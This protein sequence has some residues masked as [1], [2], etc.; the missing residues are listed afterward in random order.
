MSA[1]NLV[2]PTG[3]PVVGLPVVAAFCLNVWQ[4][5]I[6]MGLRKTSGVKY[7]TL[8]ASEAEAASDPKKKQFNCAQRAHA[9]TLEQIPY[10]LAMFG[11]LSFF[12]PL[13]ASA[14]MGIWIF[15][16][17]GYTIGYASGSPEKRINPL[18]LTQYIGLLGLFAGA[19]YV[20]A[21]KSYAHFF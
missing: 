5:Q 12:H 17:I 8:Y 2:L 20:S 18:S 14:S 9:N 19:L 16:R 11:Y 4:S 6:V 1:L 15:G 7:P 21:S 13:F 3:F 10:V